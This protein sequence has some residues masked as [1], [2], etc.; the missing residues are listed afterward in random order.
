[1]SR[2]GG[3][4]LS[5]GRLGAGSGAGTGA[6]PDGDAPTVSSFSPL[7]NATDVA[8]D[9]DLI[10]TFNET[11]VLGAV[12]VVTLKKT[13]DNSTLDSWNVASDEGSGA[14]QLEVMSSGTRALSRTARLTPSRRWPSR[15]RGHSRPRQRPPSTFSRNPLRSTMRIGTY[16]AR[17]FQPTWTARGTN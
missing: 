2:F 5:F 11:V 9:T 8:V 16:T 13:S 7:D 15:Q 3:L 17:R 1:M 6:A 14:G 10:V 4:G 12:G